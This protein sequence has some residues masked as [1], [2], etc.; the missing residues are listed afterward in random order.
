MYEEMAVCIGTCGV[1]IL[2]IHEHRRVHEDIMY[3]RT[4]YGGTP[5]MLLR[6]DWVCC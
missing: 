5:L 1:D 3:S 2:G 4:A 6:E